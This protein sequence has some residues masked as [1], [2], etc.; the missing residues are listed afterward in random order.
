MT[1]RL[2]NSELTRYVT[3]QGYAA[4]ENVPLDGPLGEV[5]A[6]LLAWLGAQLATGETLA[7]VL[8]E[9]SGQVATA[10][11]T[12]TD[13]EGNESQVATAFRPSI[14]AAVSVTAP[15]GSRT[16]VA[17]SE[18]LPAEIRDGLVATWTTLDQ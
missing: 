9:S 16:F 12:Q 4:A 5:A 11:E 3:R 14:S 17:C 13:G 7:D 8:L 2:S 1:L 6:S 15:L 18:S 10:Y